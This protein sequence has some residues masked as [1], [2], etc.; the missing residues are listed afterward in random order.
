MCLALEEKTVASQFS[1]SELACK[2]VPWSR[3]QFDSRFGCRKLLPRDSA[4]DGHILASLIC[5]A[6]K[7]L[8]PI[9]SSALPQVMF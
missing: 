6:L 7:G 1:N 4:S 5:G 2:G 8:L 3:R 9:T